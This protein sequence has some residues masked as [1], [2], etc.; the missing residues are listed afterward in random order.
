MMHYALLIA[1]VTFF[2]IFTGGMVRSMPGVLLASLAGEF[3]WSHAMISGAISFNILLY[4]AIGPFAAALMKRYRMSLLVVAALILLAL[5]AGL[6]VFMT[7][8]AALYCCWGF[9]IGSGSGIIAPVLGK[10]VSRV[11]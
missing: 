11:G 1:L 3:G 4:G 5:G 8:P 2:I 9:L 10:V 7:S 6:S